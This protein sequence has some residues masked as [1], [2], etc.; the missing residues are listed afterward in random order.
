MIDSRA[1]VL[2]AFKFVYVERFNV[3]AHP[4]PTAVIKEINFFLLKKYA[5]D[6]TS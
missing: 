2:P 1:G 5:V 4:N 6:T 3:H